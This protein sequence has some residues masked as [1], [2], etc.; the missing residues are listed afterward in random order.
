MKKLKTIL[1]AGVL[2]VSIAACGNSGVS[3]E[4][5]DKV[6]KERDELKAELEAMGSIE[7]EPEE[8]TSENEEKTEETKEFKIGET[9]EVDGKFK[10]TV[11]SVVAS[12]YR[13][14]FSET[15]P[16]AVYIINY[17]YENLG[18][19]EELYVD[20]ESKIVDN[21]GKMGT[22]Y[23]GD[24]DKYPQYVP[25]GANC[26]AEACIAVENPGSFKDYVSIYDDEYNEHTAIFNL[27]A[28]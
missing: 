15:N 25:I 13:N 28:Q 18:L 3:Q 10:I 26:E 23:P 27:D 19:N 17:T 6:V 8:K 4:E 9:W 7:Q 2:A 11:N 21:S 20:L 16:A 12:D 1:L 5:Y 22:T 14:E 24:T